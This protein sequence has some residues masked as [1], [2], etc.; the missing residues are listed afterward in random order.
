MIYESVTN[1][2]KLTI[3]RILV[4]HVYVSDPRFE[5][6]ERLVDR[7]KSGSDWMKHVPVDRD[8]A[9]VHPSHYRSDIFWIA[10]LIVSFHTDVDSA[11]FGV[12]RSL[13]KGR[14]NYLHCGLSLEALA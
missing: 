14:C 8:M 5:G 9:P 11:I 13:R 6:F 7:R 10:P 2:C 3:R 4:V 1:W 12:I